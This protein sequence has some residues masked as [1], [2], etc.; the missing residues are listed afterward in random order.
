VDDESLAVDVIATVM[1]GAHNFLGQK[2]T[3]RYLRAGEVLLTRLAERDSWE[4][5][6]AQERHSMVERAQSEAERILAEHEVPPL[7]EE[8]E[9]ELDAILAAAGQEV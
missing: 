1:S 8:Q 9:I 4:T 3:R 2:H 5:W 7:S 6:E